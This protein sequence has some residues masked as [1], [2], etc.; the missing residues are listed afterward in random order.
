VGN[1]WDE[2][3]EV[4]AKLPLLEVIIEHRLDFVLNFIEAR[5]DLLASRIL[6]FAKESIGKS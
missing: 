3:L 5:I 2:H 1:G 4:I 6:L